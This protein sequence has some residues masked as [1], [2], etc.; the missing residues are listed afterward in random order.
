MNTWDLS[1]WKLLRSLCCAGPLMEAFQLSVLE[2]PQHQWSGRILS[3][4]FN[5]SEGNKERQPESVGMQ[6]FEE[7]YP[8]CTNSR[9]SWKALRL[10][11]LGSHGDAM[12]PASLLLERVP[13]LPLPRSLSRCSC[14][15]FQRFSCTQWLLRSTPLIGATGSCLTALKQFTAPLLPAQKSSASNSGVNTFS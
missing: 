9:D 3:C 7:C 11:L 8:I 13:L 12:C 15:L 4:L 10:A 2:G 1:E 5:W 14:S 6:V